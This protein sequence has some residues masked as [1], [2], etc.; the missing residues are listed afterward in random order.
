M[1]LGD[2]I[3]AISTLLAILGAFKISRDWRTQ[4][5]SEV[6]SNISTKIYISF[7]EVTTMIQDLDVLAYTLIE[8]LNKEDILKID[9]L[10]DRII[11]ITDKNAEITSLIDIIIDY[12]SNLLLKKEVENYDKN[13]TELFLFIDNLKDIYKEWDI[14]DELL[15]DNYHKDLEEI[16]KEINNSIK[17]IKENL[18]PYIYHKY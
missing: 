3:G 10:F 8:D 5:G 14:N 7:D 16:I 6:S 11:K 13:T 9:N 4:K 17:I 18:L 2:A 12:K 1:E 15:R